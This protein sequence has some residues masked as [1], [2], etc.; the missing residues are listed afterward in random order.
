MEMAENPANNNIFRSDYRDKPI[1]GPI[2]RNITYGGKTLE[3]HECGMMYHNSDSMLDEIIDIY[4][5]VT[6]GKNYKSRCQDNQKHQ[7]HVHLDFKKKSDKYVPLGFD[8]EYER[9]E[10]AVDEQSNV[11]ITADYYPGIVRALDTLSQL[12]EQT[13]DDNNEQY[14][15]KYVPIKITDYPEYPYRGLMIDTAREYFYPDVLKTALDG[16]LLGRTNSFHWHFLDDDSFGL[17]MKSYPDMVNYTAFSDKEIYTPEDVKEIVRYAQ[18]RA[19][20][21]IPEIEGPGH[22]HITNFYPE[23]K[24]V[25][26]CFRNYTDVSSY[27]GGPPYASINP[28]DERTYTFIRKLFTDLKEILDT[29]YIHLG[30]DEVSYG[31]FSNLDITKKFLKENNMTSGDLFEY[32]IKRV[33][34]I[35]EDVYPGI[36]AGYWQSNNPVKYSGNKTVLQ[37]WGGSLKETLK[38]HPDTKVIFSSASTYYL[39]CGYYNQYAG[40]SWCGSINSWK[41]IYDFNLENEYSA[42][43][44]DRVLGGELPAWSEMNNEFNLP[45]KLFPRGAALSFR[46]WN[47]KIPKHYVE[48]PEMLVKHQYRLKSYG[49]P[50]S[51]VTQRYCEKHLHHCFGKEKY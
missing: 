24:G 51:R 6:F 4:N 2:P 34:E 14:D 19:I 40:S 21:V 8:A 23:F 28:A 49:I 35:L 41:E 37:V 42:E 50:C 11:N 44:R 45:L 10:L 5:N 1:I 36:N 39:D 32:Y 29:D 3:F 20:R 26:G 27:H 16:M 30:A 18:V 38:G 9:Y 47:S 46:L 22:L 43:D 7:I 17:F 25:I 48:V 12:I 15:I 33:R 31:C 13:S